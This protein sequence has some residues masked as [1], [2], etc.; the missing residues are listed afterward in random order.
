MVLGYMTSVSGD[1]FEHDVAQF[2]ATTLGK[3]GM[4]LPFF[5]FPSS[6]A[7]ALGRGG[8]ERYVREDRN[9][10][11]RGGDEKMSGITLEKLRGQR[12]YIPAPFTTIGCLKEGYDKIVE[13]PR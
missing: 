6:S 13:W 9:G 12:S 10:L 1:F 3:A 4:T 5:P 7:T 2:L 8:R 11:A